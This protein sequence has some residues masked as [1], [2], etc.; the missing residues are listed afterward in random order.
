MPHRILRKNVEENPKLWRAITFAS[1]IAAVL[2]VGFAF[3]Q[4]HSLSPTERTGQITDKELVL[5][6]KSESDL[7]K[8][9]E[10]DP[11]ILGIQ[12]VSISLAKNQ[13]HTIF[14]KADV[15]G[16]QAAWDEYNSRRFSL[17]PPVFAASE[18]GQNDRIAKIINGDFDCR[19]Y[20]DTLTFKFVPQ[21]ADFASWVCT[22]SVPPSFD[23]SGDFNGILTIYLPR[24]PSDVEKKNL[25]K[26]TVELSHDIFRRDVE[27]ALAK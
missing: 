26:T 10:K 18:P 5:S 8:T 11:L 23:K 13:R 21:I 19:P 16:L 6:A 25:A 1:F 20:Y 12:I 7:W 15:P 14:F 27:N 17:R 24:E 9:V 2:A 4:H 22:T 3:F